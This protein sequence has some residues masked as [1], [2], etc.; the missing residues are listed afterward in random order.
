MKDIENINAVA[1]VQQSVTQLKETVIAEK[2]YIKN[3]EYI[4]IQR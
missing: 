3:A 1:Y 2:N 4:E